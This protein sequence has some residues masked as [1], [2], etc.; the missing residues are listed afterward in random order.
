[1]DHPATQDQRPQASTPFQS[2]FSPWRKGV[3][4]PA[5]RLALLFPKETDALDFKFSTYQI[6]QPG[7]AG[8]DVPSKCLWTSMVHIQ[9]RAEILIHLF[10]EESDLT[11]IFFLEAKISIS[12]NPLSGCTFDPTHSKDRV[13]ARLLP[14][15]ANEI[16]ARRNEQMPDLNL[17]LNWHQRG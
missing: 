5:T 12:L 6:V 13:L 10:F 17:S 9:T 15:V 7:S 11:F 16:V 8:D 1:L 14:P 3:I 2:F 4:H